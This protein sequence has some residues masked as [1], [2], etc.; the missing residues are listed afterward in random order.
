MELADI[1]KKVVIGTVIYGALA[2]TPVNNKMEIKLNPTNDKAGAIT[3][4]VPG[5]YISQRIVNQEPVFYQANQEEI[6]P[7]KEAIERENSIKTATYLA[8]YY[9]LG[10]IGYAECEVPAQLPE[11]WVIQVKIGKNF[12]LEQ[13]WNGERRKPDIPYTKD[14]LQRMILAI[15]LLSFYPKKKINLW[16]EDITLPEGKTVNVYD[17]DHD[18]RAFGVV[19]KYLPKEEVEKILAL[20]NKRGELLDGTNR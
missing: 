4:L 11:D 7:T 15:N 9:P 6:Q 12:T 17:F 13:Y 16:E 2:I 14:F 18:G 20:K 8:L 19:G 10:Q 5:T 1:V 3:D